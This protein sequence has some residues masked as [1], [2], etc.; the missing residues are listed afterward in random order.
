MCLMHPYTSDVVSSSSNLF[1]FRSIPDSLWQEEKGRWLMY[2]LLW[3]LLLKV[4]FRAC[5]NGA[6]YCKELVLMLTLSSGLPVQ[7]GEHCPAFACGLS[8]TCVHLL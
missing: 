4:N 6:N 7:P 3:L 1:D 5:N 8:P 2:I